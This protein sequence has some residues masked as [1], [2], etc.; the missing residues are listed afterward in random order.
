MR[1]ECIVVVITS[2]ILRF[3]VRDVGSAK[4]QG[5]GR[6]LLSRPTRHNIVQLRAHACRAIAAVSRR[7]LR[8]ISGPRTRP[9][10]VRRKR[11]PS[12]RQSSRPSRTGPRASTGIA[13][14]PGSRPNCSSSFSF[15][16][17]RSCCN[18]SYVVTALQRY[19]RYTTDMLWPLTVFS[20]R[21]P[22]LRT[23][24]PFIRS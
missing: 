9:R 4:P 16:W 14:A 12:T 19:Q 22:T 17:S 24:A 18:E 15:S 8:A 3:G 1:N 23:R 6:P 2:P 11:L 7:G 13:L 10:V 20:D 5:R 21:R